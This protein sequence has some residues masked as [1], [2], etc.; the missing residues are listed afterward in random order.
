MKKRGVFFCICLLCFMIAGIFGYYNTGTKR[1]NAVGKNYNNPKNYMENTQ[2]DKEDR[3]I[4]SQN[5]ESEKGKGYTEE[6]QE[7]PLLKFC[8]KKTRIKAG[9]SY[10]FKVKKENVSGEI[11]FHSSDE[12]IASISQKGKLTAKQEGSTWITASVQNC[13]TKLKITVL[14]KKIVAIDPGHS[15]DPAQGVEPVGPGSSTLKLRDSGGTYGIV[16]GTGEYQLTLKLAKKLRK[17]LRQKGYKVVL[18]RE[19]NTV[20]ISNAERAQAANKENADIFVRIHADGSELSSVYGASAM[21][22]TD[23]NPFVSML[24]KKSRKLSDCILQE[25]CELSG[26]K[27][28]G[29]F[30]RDDLA[31]SNWAVM[32]VTLI[33]VGFMTN[34][35]EDRQLQEDDYQDQLAAGMAAGIE[36]YFGY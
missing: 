11:T 26:A 7:M 24:S 28:R 14:P 25:M 16:S 6:R 10:V 3:Q 18:T 15:R 22:P 20:S 13:S 17:I 19:N 4:I 21:Y 1:Q 9:N 33:E 34:P 2:E 36:S 5:L 27:N 30:G 32:P 8:R 12:K 29:S 23:K 31:G 35:A